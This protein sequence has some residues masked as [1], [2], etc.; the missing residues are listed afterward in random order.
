M[1]A[2]LEII[3]HAL[4]LDR[5]GIFLPCL[6]HNR[7]ISFLGS[8]SVGPHACQKERLAISQMTSPSLR[9]QDYKAGG[10][11]PDY[12]VKDPIPEVASQPVPLY[13][14]P[15][16]NEKQPACPCRTLASC[17]GSAR[18]RDGPTP[19]MIL[20]AAHGAPRRPRR[21]REIRNILVS[22]LK[23][24]SAR[25]VPALARRTCSGHDPSS[26]PSLTT[27][28]LFHPSLDEPDSTFGLSQSGALS[29]PDRARPQ[30]RCANSLLR[31]RLRHRCRRRLSFSIR[32]LIQCI[33]QRLGMCFP[34]VSIPNRQMISGANKRQF[35]SKV[36]TLDD[37]LR[38]DHTA[39]GIPAQPVNHPV[40]RFVVLL[41]I[42]PRHQ[43]H[44]PLGN[45]LPVIILRL[46]PGHPIAANATNQ[47]LI[48]PCFNDFLPKISGHKNSIFII[49]N[50]VVLTNQEERTVSTGICLHFSVTSRR[51]LGRRPTLYHTPIICKHEAA[52][53]CKLWC[54][55]GTIRVNSGGLGRPHPRL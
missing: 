21:G 47:R 55:G 42:F 1:D 19:R 31:V 32:N 4:P 8:C 53:F 24:L 6:Y 40:V 41:F 22:K 51:L 52:N 9:S 11:I 26:I 18:L 45:Q 50:R 7:K 13:C 28:G 35:L 33:E 30:P 38:H 27:R 36:R 15:S 29:R 34:G 48:L 14:Y 54:W 37:L 5:P 44:G 2:R 46:K 10:R 17:L 39:L 25:S 23:P 20:P 16:R 43:V 12:P 49:Q 3:R